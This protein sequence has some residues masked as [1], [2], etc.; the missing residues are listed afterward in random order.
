MATIAQVA[1]QR[2]RQVSV[3]RVAY[4]SADTAGEIFERKLKSYANKKK[5]I[6]SKDMSSLNTLYRDYINK[7]GQIEKE[8]TNL[9][10]LVNA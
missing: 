5:M 1:A 10:N 7:M 6:E 3:V 2:R 9:N 8:L 4:R